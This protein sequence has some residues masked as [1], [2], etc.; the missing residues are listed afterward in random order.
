[1]TAALES[2][3]TGVDEPASGKLQVLGSLFDL[4]ANLVSAS[5]STQVNVQYLGQL[6]MSHMTTV[7]ATLKEDVSLVELGKP[8]LFIR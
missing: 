1:M 8:V 4:L 6:V 2:I 7:L 5:A 3:K